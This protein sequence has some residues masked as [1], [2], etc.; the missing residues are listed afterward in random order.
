M[1]FVR[2]SDLLLI[3]KVLMGARH[4][5]LDA[6]MDVVIPSSIGKHHYNIFNLLNGDLYDLMYF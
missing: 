2:L 6:D 5:T 3:S 1:G 4:S